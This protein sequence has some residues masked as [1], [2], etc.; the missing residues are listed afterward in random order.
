[1]NPSALTPN[2]AWDTR[3]HRWMIALVA[4][5]I[6]HAVLMIGVHHWPGKNVEYLSGA[7][8]LRLDLVLIAPSIATDT[9][10][11]E[12]TLSETPIEQ[13][14]VKEATL[15]PEPTK[16]ADTNEPTA[17]LPA[18]V[19]TIETTASPEPLV[20]VVTHTTKAPVN[21]SDS[22]VPVPLTTPTNNSVSASPLTAELTELLGEKDA[23]PD[24]HHQLMAH[25][26]RHKRYPPLA[27]QRRQQG[28]AHVRFSMDRQG[29]LISNEITQTSGS[30][31]L[32][33]GALTMLGR[34]QPLPPPPAE[35]SGQI[36][37]VEVP[38]QFSLNEH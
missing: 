33:R 12:K 26:Q 34:A 27:R 14:A 16:P 22:T 13:P 7:A 15:T 25:L 24:W 8:P 36:L 18:A 37:E 21:Y 23:L 1:M 28:T 6:I 5:L 35:V 4:A 3:S 31:L 17:E 20:S 30:V 29:N 10:P 2:A 32:D 38:V 19:F 9:Q 11:G